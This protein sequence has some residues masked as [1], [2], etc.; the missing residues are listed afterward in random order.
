M[1]NKTLTTLAA[2]ADA[3]KLLRA[4]RDELAAALRTLMGHINGD[5]ENWPYIGPAYKSAAD[6]LAKVQGQ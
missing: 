6:A 3:N 2:Y 1:D 4:Q 5:P